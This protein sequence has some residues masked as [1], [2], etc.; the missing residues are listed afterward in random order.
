MKYKALIED[1]EFKTEGKR[2]IIALLDAIRQCVKEMKINNVNIYNIR[3]VEV[4]LVNENDKKAI[5]YFT[6]RH[7]LEDDKASSIY[8]DHDYRILLFKELTIK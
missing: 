4:N 1:V 5:Y 7:K 6:I 3:M 2:P 8:Y